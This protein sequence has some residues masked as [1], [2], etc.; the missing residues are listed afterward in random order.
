MPGSTAEFCS[1]LEG[2]LQEADETQLW[3][4]LLRDDCGV[5]TQDLQGL[6]QETNELVAMFVTMVERARCRRD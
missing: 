2:A 4:E 3:L 6:L 5:E 1:K